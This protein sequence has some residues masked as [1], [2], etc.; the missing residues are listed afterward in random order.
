MSEAEA[1]AAVIIKTEESEEPQVVVDERLIP[2]LKWRA[3]VVDAVDS[4]LMDLCDRYEFESKHTYELD[5][6]DSREPLKTRTPATE[7]KGEDSKT[8]PEEEL[9]ALVLDQWS[10]S[11]AFNVNLSSTLMPK[12]WVRLR[13]DLQGFTKDANKCNLSLSILHKSE[14]SSEVIF[15]SELVPQHIRPTCMRIAG[16]ALKNKAMTLSNMAAFWT[17]MNQ[18]GS[19]STEQ[20][21][22]S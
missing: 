3:A 7:S 6:R 13:L 18:L 22:A 17:H 1:T 11:I 2:G 12:V 14:A 4:S 9:I 10:A 15:A 5:I 19:K 16:T 20:S 21:S 8:A